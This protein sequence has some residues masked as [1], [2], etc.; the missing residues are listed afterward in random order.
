MLKQSNQVAAFALLGG[1]SL[2]SFG[3][4]E[5]STDQGVNSATD[6]SIPVAQRLDPELLRQWT[7][8][9]S[10]EC[11][12]EM[13]KLAGWQEEL[14]SGKRRLNCVS[15]GTERAYIDVLRVREWLL[16]NVR[17]LS[18]SNQFGKIEVFFAFEPAVEASNKAVFKLRDELCRDIESSQ[19]S[20]IAKENLVARL[21]ALQ[22]TASEGAVEEFR[23]SYA[24]AG[25]EEWDTLLGAPGGIIN[26]GL[27]QI[28]MGLSRAV[29]V[30]SFG[31]MGAVS[32][33]DLDESTAAQMVRAVEAFC[34]ASANASSAF[35][36]FEEDFLQYP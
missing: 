36:A 7:G 32:Q 24:P 4:R 22:R 33:T 19:L 27:A 35:R 6:A 28:A 3:C 17:A 5:R 31:G 20:K 8:P 21:A 16:D 14:S 23:A 15:A 9:Q 26:G 2:F 30:R 18:R 10:E 25:S 29:F 13:R 34:K 1:L 11:I 12:S